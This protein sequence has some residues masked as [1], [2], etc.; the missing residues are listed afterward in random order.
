[1]SH[2]DPGG[3]VTQP[4]S[5]V[6]SGAVY[7][8]YHSGVTCVVH[9]EFMPGLL[10]SQQ[11]NPRSFCVIYVII[12]KTIKDT[13]KIT[14]WLCL[15]LFQKRTSCHTLCKLVPALAKQSNQLSFA[16]LLRFLRM[17]HSS[18]RLSLIPK[19]SK[20]WGL[21]NLIP[22]QLLHTPFLKKKNPFINVTRWTSCFVLPNIW[23]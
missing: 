17:P 3:F 15:G 2:Y 12:A 4:R 23:Q 18:L 7:L 20:S 21:Q 14:S 11:S 10:Y 19:S 22:I 16:S 8:E 5:D 6:N 1:M 13:V 9:K